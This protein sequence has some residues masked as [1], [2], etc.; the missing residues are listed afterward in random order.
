MPDYAWREIDRVRVVGKATPVTIY[1]PM[2]PA[3]SSQVAA[4]LASHRRALASYRERDFEVA[5]AGF[6]ELA[7]AHP[8]TA[9]YAYFRTR[10]A[11]YR[12]S[13]PPSAWEGAMVF[14]TK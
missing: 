3:A 9:L 12:S 11:L 4:E 10:C 6:A 7:A 8:S 5:E 1:E 2:G 13:P 14:A